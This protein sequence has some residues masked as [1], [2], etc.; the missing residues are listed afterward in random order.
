MRILAVLLCVISAGVVTSTTT[1]AEADFPGRDKIARL[2]LDELVG[3]FLASATPRL[4]SYKA[5]QTLNASARGGKMTAT[6]NG[7]AVQ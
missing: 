1:V 5:K 4:T 2:G 7:Q 6:L 3:K